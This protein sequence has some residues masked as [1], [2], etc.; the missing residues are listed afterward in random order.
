MYGRGGSGSVTGD[1]GIESRLVCVYPLLFA[2]EQIVTD[3]T[4]QISSLFLGDGVGRD[5]G[6]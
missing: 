5:D 2:C 3:D 4:F 1:R 6:E